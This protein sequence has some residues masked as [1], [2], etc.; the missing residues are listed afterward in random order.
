MLDKENFMSFLVRQALVDCNF[1]LFYYIGSTI[2]EIDSIKFNDIID[3][4]LCARTSKAQLE[5]LQRV[6]GLHAE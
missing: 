6:A 1:I 5:L 3:Q 4:N 2:S